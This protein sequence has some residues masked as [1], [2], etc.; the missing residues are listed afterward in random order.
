MDPQLRMLL[1]MVYE[2]LESAGLSREQYSGS[3]TGVF[4]AL[5]ITDFDRNMLKDIIGKSPYAML[6][7][8]VAMIANRISHAL[9]LRGPSLTLDTGCS[10]GLV[11]LH[12]ACNALRNGECETAI[13]V[14]R[15][16]T[17]SPNRVAEMSN[18]HFLNSTGR[19]YPFDSRGDGYG[20]GEGLVVI[21]LK[22]MQD[23]VDGRF[24]L[25]AVVRSSAVNQDGYT[26]EGITYP[27]GKAQEDLIKY[28]FARA[29]L[30][31]HDVAYVEA[32]GTGTM[33]GDFQE[34]SAVANTFAGPNRS[35]PLFVGS[36]K[37]NIGHTENTSGLAG[38]LKSILVLQHKQIPPL[39]CFEKPKPGLPLD[40]INLPTTLLPLPQTPGLP[41]RVSVNSFGYGGTNSHVI[42]EE[43][44][45]AD[46]LSNGCSSDGS[47]LL[48]QLSAD[49][50]AS[51]L[52]IMERY[53]S[54]L[55]L[56]PGTSLVDISYTLR[57]RR[58][59]FPWRF[60]CVAET[61]AELGQ[62]LGDGLLGSIQAPPSKKT[63]VAFIFTGQGAQWTGM[64]RELLIKENGT[65]PV[66]RDSIH[67]STKILLDLGA[68]WNL[69]AAL[70]GTGAEAGLINTA[71]LAQP[72]TTALQR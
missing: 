66:F 40:Q 6:G 56:H 9:D 20:R 59:T 13:V 33:A 38:L 67:A 21:I 19:S 15:N 37:G 23:A 39:A 50:R 35:L 51:L 57:E 34:L 8:D 43:T 70:S 49:C 46:D 26:P 16:L 28:T 65:A 1:E 45:K 54:W 18:L 53:H 5:F 42:L 12:Q 2:A 31:P 44:I 4:G 63:S 11:A 14:S 72:V 55:K 25:Q 32:H 41:S 30:R 10:G 7:C 36:I 52:A 64:G 17:L 47:P 58:T 69:E 61:H 24:P 29:G 62:K 68:T 3:N 48:F 60:S 22:R 71:E 27:N